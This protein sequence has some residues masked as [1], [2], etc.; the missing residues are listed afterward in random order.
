MWTDTEEGPRGPLPSQIH[1]GDGEDLEASRWQE[2]VLSDGS[3]Y[4]FED[5]WEGPISPEVSPFPRV[6]GN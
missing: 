5:M 6:R 2:A 1:S 3:T 4:V